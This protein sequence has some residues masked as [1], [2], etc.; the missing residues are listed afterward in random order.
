MLANYKQRPFRSSSEFATAHLSRESTPTVVL[1]QKEKEVKIKE[2]PTMKR[3]SLHLVAGGNGTFQNV[4]DIVEK[5]SCLLPQVRTY[6]CTHFSSRIFL[7][8]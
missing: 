7:W 8:I 3:S 5:E 2:T 4:T 6:A 1:R